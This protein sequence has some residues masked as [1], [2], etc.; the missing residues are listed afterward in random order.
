MRSSSVNGKPMRFVSFMLSF[1]VAS[2][3]CV[4]AAWSA[5][6]I[7]VRY[8]GCH[9]CAKWEAEIGTAYPQSAEGARAPLRRVNLRE[10][11]DDIEFESPPAVTPTFILVHDGRE[12]GRII[13][14][15]G[16]DFFWPM[17]TKLLDAHPDETVPQL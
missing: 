17:L 12:L 11:P 6:L 13:G 7:F 1:A 8:D 3:I 9:W 4:S 16:A 14:Y 2:W 15:P 5:E 10:I